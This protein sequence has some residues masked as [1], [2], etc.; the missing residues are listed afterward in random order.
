ML[1]SK[2]FCVIPS[3]TRTKYW[4]RIAADLIDPFV[5]DA[6][7]NLPSSYTLLILR[8]MRSVPL[9]W[10]FNS[11]LKSSVEIYVDFRVNW[12]DDG[13]HSYGTVSFCELFHF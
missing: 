6:M 5:L 13:T 12:I 8:I 9:Q 7:F 11:G 3:H 2:I 1:L 10:H 4:R